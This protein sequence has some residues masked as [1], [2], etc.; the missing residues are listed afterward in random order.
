MPHQEMR[1][2]RES[3]Q[4][5]EE[6]AAVPG[7]APASVRQ[8]PVRVI[9]GADVQDMDLA[10]RTV[11][12][13][14]AVARAIFGINAAATALID[15]QAAA[16]EQR[17]CAGQMLEFVKHSGQKGAVLRRRSAAADRSVVEIAGDEAVWRRNGRRVGSLPLRDLWERAHDGDRDS[18]HW[19]LYPHQVRLMVERSHRQATGVVIEMP[20]GP[21]QVRWISDD[22]SDGFGPGA[23]YEERYLSFPWVVLVVVFVGGDL[24][25]LQQAFYRTRPI[26]SLDDPL[27]FTNLLNV[28][29]GYGQESWVCLVN[30]RRALGRLEWEERIHALTEHFWRAAFNR[31][32]E[33]H[34]GNSFWGSQRAID[35]R[36]ASP[37][38]W[39]TATREDPYFA[40]H[41][42][43]PQAP[44]SLRQALERMLETV[45]PARPIERAEQLVTLMQQTEG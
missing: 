9:A 36:L 18:R 22:S 7:S 15:G 41:I 31:S 39:E 11:A 1:R 16:E 38:A 4:K 26:R 37:A 21:R 30:L 3:R 29:Q 17:L 12:E 10:G 34:E 13:A 27:H 45:A 23:S 14:R 19:S 35:P 8:A 44:Y 2:Q 42:A 25:N 43:W 5:L 33:A 6:S 24:C 40:L 32:S 28:A 20:P